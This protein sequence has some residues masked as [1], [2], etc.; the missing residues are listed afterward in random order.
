[1]LAFMDEVDAAQ[2]HQSEAGSE[3]QKEVG[4]GRKRASI[5]LP[6]LP[7]FHRPPFRPPPSHLSPPLLQPP[8]TS[9]APY[10]TDQSRNKTHSISNNPNRVSSCQPRHSTTQPSRQMHEPCVQRVASFGSQRSSNQNRHHQS[11]NAGRAK[12]TAAKGGEK[13]ETE[14]GVSLGLFC[15]MRAKKGSE[16]GGDS[17]DDS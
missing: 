12:A 16:G 11:V 5:L 1:M 4:R 17:R 3:G 14:G 8:H 7:L 10:M 13:K 15:R 6:S 2:T 9:L